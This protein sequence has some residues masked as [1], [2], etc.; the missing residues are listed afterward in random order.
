MKSEN[1]VQYVKNRCK[2]GNSMR[3]QYIDN[4]R[5][6]TVVLVV[7][8]HV[9]YMFNGVLTEGV[10]GPFM[11][12]QWWDAFQYILYPWFMLL[13][14]VISGMCSRYY[15]ENHSDREFLKSRT[16]KLLV[17]STLGILTF[18]W[19]TGFFNMAFSGAF[20]QM[21]AI[22]GPILWLI[23]SVSGTGVLWYIQVLWILSVLLI[24][25][26]KLDKDRF[27]RICG[28]CPVPLIA[29]FVIP[30]F[31]AA[32]ILNAPVI[33]VY[34]FG[35]YGLGFL[36]GYFVFSHDEV[37]EKLEKG[38]AIYCGLAVCLAGIYVFVYF[39]EDYAVPP[40]RDTALSIVF[41][42]TTVLAMLTLFKRYFDKKTKLLSFLSRRSFGLYVFHY[43]FIAAAAYLMHIY[44]NVPALLQYLI[45]AVSAFVGSYL[46]EE[47]VSRIPV[48]RFLV[49]GI[50]KKKDDDHV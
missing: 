33:C 19:I 4:L 38:W 26:R 25:V 31:G 12:H 40:V 1:K 28:K 48:L 13:L 46:L 16:A 36:I 27:Y 35:I 9:I 2:G 20:K 18:H 10:I 15:L 14:F 32:Q 21:P 5:C 30:L 49:L 41:A 47:I 39:G 7:L 11:E 3:K 17:P 23:M 45:C 22:P 29:A 42:W 43:T 6:V 37:M 24:L 34:R 50:K 44:G 8:Y